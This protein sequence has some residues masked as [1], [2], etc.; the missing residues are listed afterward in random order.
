MQSVPK[1][2]RV[3]NETFRDN[4]TLFY[5][6]H[7]NIS[8][9]KNWNKWSAIVSSLA[10]YDK[11]SPHTSIF[12]II[13]VEA[14]EED[15]TRLLSG[16]IRYQHLFVSYKLT[17]LRDADFWLGLRNA[18]FIEE[19]SSSYPY[20]FPTW[21]GSIDDAIA[22]AAHL[23][24]FSRI[25]DVNLKQKRIESLQNADITIENNI[26]PSNLYLIT[27]YFI[28]NSNKR[29][30]E[31]R[32]CLMNNCTNDSIDKI[33]LLN[34]KDL[35]SEWSSMKGNEKI[36]QIII[37]KRMEYKD[38]LKVTI[39]HIPDNTIVV[40]ANADIYL[41]NT[42]NH[43]YTLNMKNKMLALLRWDVAENGEE[44]K[45]FGPHPDSQ[46][47]WI[48]LSD[49]VKE[50]TW[51][52]DDFSYQL[53]RAGCDNRF[54]FDMFRNKFLIC[55]PANTIK[56]L[57]LHNSQIRNYNKKDIV[58][59][60]HYI[61]T[62]PNSITDVRHVVANLQKPINTI[63]Q[64]E[65][66]VNIKCPN[67]ANGNTWC[68]MVARG[69][70][71]NWTFNKTGLYSN[72][73]NIYEWKDCFMTNNGIVYNL[74]NVFV[75]PEIEKFLSGVGHNIAI[76]VV[77]RK[78][79]Y[80]VIYGVP[81]NN[82][83]KMTN[84]DLYILYYMSRVFPLLE[85]NPEGH[86]L[87]NRDILGQVELFKK[88][89]EEYNTIDWNKDASYYANKIVGYVP[90]TTEISKEDIFNIR[91]HFADWKS[92]PDKE[93][94]TCMILV[95]NDSICSDSFVKLVSVVLGESWKVDSMPASASGVAAYKALAGKHMCIFFGGPKSESVWA[96][97][98]SLPEGCKVFEFQNELKVDG[99]F[100]HMAA[101]AKLDS[102][103]ITLH[104]GNIDEMQK[105][106]IG[107]FEKLWNSLPA[108]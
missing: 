5:A 13:L 58:P 35:S 38:L 44:P 73:L 52:F 64:S 80:S 97:L 31:I 74:R 28:H 20:V 47:S 108:P 30:R 41:D 85:I 11:W 61:F 18:L 8:A 9:T 94:K 71:F 37:G 79:Y 21:N 54:T 89:S 95:D 91:D 88:K 87:V 34:E 3:K 55:N 45:I 40:Y 72:K 101:A 76:D 17:S 16:T 7:Q 82:L 27:Q 29:A 24:R 1:I 75:G 51:N 6:K 78:K 32:K 77:S 46:D 102:W 83:D 4:L 56:T 12:G 25:V 86:I 96:K 100:Q 105:Q 106:A 36:Q 81:L 65:F 59:S 69:N 39:D 53:G 103:I 62:Y 63:V 22:C 66:S 60:T 92:E 48:V 70:R 10:D 26:L 67:A 99:E 43:V 93:L 68:T 90:N 2:I 84:I 19:I 104:K 23:F 98:W 15:I 49:S 33:I 42:I 50:R 57:H 107:H 14:S